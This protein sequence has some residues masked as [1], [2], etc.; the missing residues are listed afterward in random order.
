MTPAWEPIW[1]A[2]RGSLSGPQEPTIHG[3]VE[4]RHFLKSVPPA[5]PP[6]A[7]ISVAAQGALHGCN[8]HLTTG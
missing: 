4:A 7:K 2:L 1:P 8:Y 3:A 5:H 6:S